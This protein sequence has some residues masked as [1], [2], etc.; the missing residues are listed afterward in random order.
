MKSVNKIFLVFFLL[1]YTAIIYA[2]RNTIDSLQKVLLRQ[3]EDTNKVK[4]LIRLSY[5]S[6]SKH[7]YNIAFEYA[8]KPKIRKQKIRSKKYLSF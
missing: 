6:S 1:T 3:K 7:N 5:E 8:V 2:Q 4:T